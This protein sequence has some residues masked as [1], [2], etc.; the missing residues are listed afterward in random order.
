NSWGNRRCQRGRSRRTGFRASW[1]WKTSPLNSFVV[2]LP[3]RKSGSHFFWKPSLFRLHTERAVEADDFA[4]QIVVAD[5]GEDEIGEFLRPAEAGRI[6]DGGPK[7]V[8]GFGG[9]LIEQRGEE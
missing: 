1:C 8:D 3:N 6:G 4:V 9:E 2:A 7:G 5:H